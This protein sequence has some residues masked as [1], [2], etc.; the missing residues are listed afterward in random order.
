MPPIHYVPTSQSGYML[1]EEHFP[2]RALVTRFSPDSTLL[3][4]N[5]EYSVL[6][7]QNLCDQLAWLF[8]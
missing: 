7:P 8:L 5:P 6:D 1:H 3:A 2:Q 4:I